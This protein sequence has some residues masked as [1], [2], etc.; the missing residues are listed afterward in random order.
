MHKFQSIT[1]SLFVSLLMVSLDLSANQKLTDDESRGYARAC[2][3]VV[4]DK[5]HCNDGTSIFDELATGDKKKYYED[6]YSFW[7][8]EVLSISTRGAVVKAKVEVTYRCEVGGNKGW[9]TP[10]TEVDKYVYTCL[11]ENVAKGSFP[12]PAT[13][14]RDTNGKGFDVYAYRE[15]TPS[16]SNIFVEEKTIQKGYSTIQ[17]HTENTFSN[18]W[19]IRYRGLDLAKQYFGQYLK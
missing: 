18:Y 6:K 19:S 3:K 4:K 9:G 11:S 5:F 16:S 7:P 12:D 8:S 13:F 10:Q 2:F 14:L 17:Q 1:G 15:K